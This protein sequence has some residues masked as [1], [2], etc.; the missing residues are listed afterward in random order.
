M[1]N[2]DILFTCNPVLIN[3][4][5]FMRNKGAWCLN[6]SFCVSVFKYFELRTNVMSIIPKVYFAILI[7]KICM[8]I[9]ETFEAGEPLMA[10]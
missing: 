5:Y 7:H 10:L 2:T 9:S 4:A 1:L 6:L 3:F 8:V